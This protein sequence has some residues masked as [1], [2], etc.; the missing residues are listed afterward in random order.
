MAGLNHVFRYGGAPAWPRRP[1]PRLA[2]YLALSVA[3]WLLPPW[4]ALAAGAGAALLGR[5]VDWPGWLRGLGWLW[6]FILA[7]PLAEAAAQA[8][9][10]A[11]EPAG[12][13]AAAERS[14]S[15]LALLA[16][17]QWLSASTT[18]FEIRQ[19]LPLVLRPL[20][21]SRAEL[22]GLMGALALGFLPWVAE[23]A[24]RV[25]EAALL[26]GLPRR[27]PAAALRALALPVGVRLV[28]KARQCGD[29]LELRGR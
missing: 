2:L 23:Q 21:R 8:A 28:A 20:G 11:A 7:P 16:A 3:A 14:L 1:G 13:A 5:A 18:L 22:L 29:A 19:V 9:A 25:R 12:L 10:G 27:R 24:G 6:L 17:A 4:G 15:L 26:R